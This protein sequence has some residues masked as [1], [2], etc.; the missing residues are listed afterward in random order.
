MRDG[1]DISDGHKF[2]LVSR[3]IESKPKSRATILR[4][5]GIVFDLLVCASVFYLAAYLVTKG[6]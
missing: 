4:I 6:F 5:L 3:Q 1:I 2:K